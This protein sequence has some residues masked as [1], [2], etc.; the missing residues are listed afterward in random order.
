MNLQQLRYFLA[1]AEHGSFSA[2]AAELHLAQPSLS[3]QVRRLEDELGAPLFQRLGR[4]V[5]LTEAGRALRPHAIAALEEVEAARSAV[6][7]VNALRGGTA[8]FGLHGIA[9]YYGL[10]AELVVEFRRAHPDVSVRLVG[11]NSVDVVEGLASGAIEAGMIALPI[12]DTG[13]ELKPVLRDELLV[14]GADRKRLHDAPM[15]IERFATLPLVLPDA[16]WARDD[17]QRRQ[18]RELAQRAGVTVAPV[19][20]VE[21]PEVAIELAARGVGDTIAARGFLVGLGD[22]LP[23]NL[24]WTAFAEPLYDDFAF[25]WRRGA[26]L[27]PATRA[28]MD[29]AEERLARFARRIERHPARR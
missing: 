21:D 16:S 12:D 8:A 3:E 24:G 28:L 1:A 10:D 17:P 2:A 13:L 6:A 9:H 25:V 23:A 27:S 11:Q 7:G 26:R 22:R 15:T 19:A 18:L 29:L 5:A 14:V 20:D 4:G